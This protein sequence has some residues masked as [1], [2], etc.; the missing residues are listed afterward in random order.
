M[1]DIGALLYVEE[2]CF[3]TF[4]RIVKT[5]VGVLC[6]RFTTMASGLSEE[7]SGW[8]V[9]SPGFKSWMLMMTCRPRLVLAKIGPN[10]EKHSLIWSKLMHPRAE[11]SSLKR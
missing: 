5:P 7:R 6:P 1:F 4:S 10:S 11:P 3:L 2:K 9:N 8:Q